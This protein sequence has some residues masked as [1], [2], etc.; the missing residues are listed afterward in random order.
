MI[1]ACTSSSVIER[2]RRQSVLGSVVEMVPE[3]SSL[4][5]FGPPCRYDVAFVRVAVG[6]D[7][8][9]LEAVGETDCVDPHLAI[10]VTVVGSFHG[11]SIENPRRILKG[12]PMPADICG[13]L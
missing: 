5:R 3:V 11:W 10:V 12:D 13:I 4:M 9:D 6:I 7:H 1:A 8:R 2:R